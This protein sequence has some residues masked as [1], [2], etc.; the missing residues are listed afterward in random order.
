MRI[1]VGGISHETSTFVNAPTTIAD[2]ES[3]FGLFRGKEIVDRFT[4]ANICIGG[5]LDGARK[6][7]YEPAP[8]LWGFAYP[9]GRIVRNDYDTLKAEFLQRLRDDEAANGPVDGVLLD[10]HGAMVIE[11]I[12]DGDG[13]FIAS[14]REVVG[15]DRPVIV[16][17]D[18]HSNHSPLR[19]EAA[20]CIVGFDTYPHIDMA[21]RGREAAD[22][23]VRMVQGEIRPVMAL[24]QLPLF[25]STPC[26][27]TE[28]PPMDEAMRKVHELE[29][30][31]GILCI[32]LAAG[33]AWADVPDVG[34]SVIVAA[35]GDEA[36]ARKTADDLATWIWENRMKWYKPP[37]TVRDALAA[38]ETA[39]KY[40]I[41]L[42]DHSDNTGGG[43]PGDSTEILQTFVDMDLQDALLLYMVH[44]EVAQQA[45]AAGVGASISISLGGWSD[46]VQG[47]PIRM[48]AEVMAI[49]NGDFAYDGPM[50]AGLTGNMGCSARL[51]S[52]G[53]N[54]VVVTAQEQPL[55]PAFARTLGIDPAAMR[56]IAV[57]SAVHFRASFEPI[58][59]SIHSVDARA[60]HNHVLSELKYTKRRK[61]MFP[62]EIL[63]E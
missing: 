11:G 60:I 21:D 61:K 58:S 62:I 57:K 20:D 43:S 5:F 63:P 15:P 30:R 34:T 48:D 6:H 9:S 32:T 10:L 40:P 2:F 1:A 29:Q 3:G 52:G 17:F 12:D 7:G 55:G 44:P 19:V 46:P 31:H 49:S 25:W 50:Y 42:A 36:L 28:H 13:D 39:G 24:H 33:F 8:L 47:P 27:A 38:G 56:Y 53:V 4:E 22:L 14:V 16:T 37:V 26:Q 45:H 18:L 59:G 23:I 51:R 54:I 41:V 35:D